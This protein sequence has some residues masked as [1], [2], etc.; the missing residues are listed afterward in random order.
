M[1]L[2]NALIEKDGIWT[3]RDF[4]NPSLDYQVVNGVLVPDEG[5]EMEE[6]LNSAKMRDPRL[7]DCSESGS[8]VQLI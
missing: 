8:N 6:R 1:G 2:S 3:S 7:A 5:T 4:A